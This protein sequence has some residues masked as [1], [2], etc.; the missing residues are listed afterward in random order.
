MRY[1]QQ[2]KTATRE[3][4]LKSASTQFRAAGVKGTSLPEVMEEAGLT[5]G[6]F[7]RHFESKDA[8]FAEAFETAIADT[9]AAL[10]A[11]TGDLTGAAWRQRVA[12]VYLSRSHRSNVE[13]GCALPALAADIARA[14]P[15]VRA[16]CENSVRQLAEGISK[17]L[18]EANDPDREA[19]LDDAWAFLALLVGGLSLARMVEDEETSGAILRACRRA[20]PTLVSGSGDPP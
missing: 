17:H 11:A 19:N 16:R 3:R 4:I 6:G 13:G 8:L 14:N 15:E 10:E 7:Y 5:V 9:A 18:S 12:Q 2:H 1:D 20:A